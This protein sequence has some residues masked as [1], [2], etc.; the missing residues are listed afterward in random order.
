YWVYSESIVGNHE[1]AS[2]A[3]PHPKGLYHEIDDGGKH[4]ALG[5]QERRHRL[6]Q[7]VNRTRSFQRRDEVTDLL[8]PAA[9][10]RKRGPNHAELGGPVKT[11]RSHPTHDR[12][13]SPDR[14]GDSGAC[15]GPEAPRGGRA[16]WRSTN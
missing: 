10:A 4:R 7:E 11:A 16:W 5:G 12:R 3:L 14:G 2:P 1:V 13:F 9:P 15:E 6:R 8:R